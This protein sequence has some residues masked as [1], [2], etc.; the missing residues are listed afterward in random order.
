MDI[1]KLLTTIPKGVLC[2]VLFSITS[3]MIF[4]VKT[5]SGKAISSGVDPRDMQCRTVMAKVQQQ[6]MASHQEQNSLHQVQL[7]ER[8]A[9]AV[10]QCS[11]S[12]VHSRLTCV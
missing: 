11:L 2:F 6:K 12:G 1:R 8:Y 4:L 7:E 10:R 5:S 3:Y 9:C